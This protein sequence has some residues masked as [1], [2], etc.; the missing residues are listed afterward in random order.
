MARI[1]I[2]GLNCVATIPPNVSRG[3]WL[4]GVLKD[5]ILNGFYPGGARLRETELQTEL[6]FS[7]GPVRE[8]LQLTVAA[9][10][11]ESAPWQGVRVIV[12]SPH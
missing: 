7:N 9:T 6:G 5:R 11:A 12:T 10:L 2:A 4:A 8:A 1:A 3:A